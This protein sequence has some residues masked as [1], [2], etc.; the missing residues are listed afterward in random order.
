MLDQINSIS[1][2]ASG[3]SLSGIPDFASQPASFGRV[4]DQ[5]EGAEANVQ[6]SLSEYINGA[7]DRPVHEI[8]L[9]IERNRL[10]LSLVLQLRNKIVE[11]VQELYRTPV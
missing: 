8:M 4:L 7:S 1:A 3:S 10:M 2:V 9:D 5:L 6:T 11:G